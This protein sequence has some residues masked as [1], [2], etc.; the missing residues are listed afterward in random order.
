[1]NPA[2]WRELRAYL[3]K[4]KGT[5]IERQRKWNLDHDGGIAA[6]I[7]MLNDVQE[8]MRH[9]LARRRKAAKP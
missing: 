2:V 9:I 8:H 7:Y 1:M 4:R 5:L 6:A 3:R